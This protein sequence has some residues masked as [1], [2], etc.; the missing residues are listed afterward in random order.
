MDLMLRGKVALVTGGSRGL[1]AAVCRALAAE[2]AGVAVNYASSREKAEA[3]ADALKRDFSVPAAA[4]GADVSDEAQAEALFDEAARRLGVVDILVNN[5]GICPVVNIVDLEFSQ[6]RRVMGA[7]LDSVFLCSRAFARRLIEAG[8][9]GR[10]VNIVS[11]AAFNGSKR[12]KTPYSASKGAV[13]S[14]TVS[15]AKEVA[16]HG[17]LVNAVAP[18]M[19]DTDMVAQTLEI[20][21]EREKYAAAIPLGRLGAVEEV[22]RMVAFLAGDAA[23]YS[24]GGVFDV[25]G[26]MMSR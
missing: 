14:F 21:G 15:F 3:V 1:G 10:I 25:T 12:G 17:I 6:W 2:G 8:R 11:Q 26:G 4:I 7:N 23:S 13:V 5:A 16:R 19:M 9:P 22:A 24:T 18:G 20:P